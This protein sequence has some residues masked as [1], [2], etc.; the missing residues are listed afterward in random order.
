MARDAVRSKRGVVFSFQFLV[1]RSSIVHAGA[2]SGW[3]VVCPRKARNKELAAVSV[4]CNFLRGSEGFSCFVNGAYRLVPVFVV[5]RLRLLFNKRNGH[6]RGSG[7][8][9]SWCVVF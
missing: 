8:W 4:H 9:S 2:E 3:V 6:L 5:P 7:S 1:F